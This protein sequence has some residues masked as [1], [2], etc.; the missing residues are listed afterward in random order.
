MV[1]RSGESLT[2]GAASLGKG[3]R[4]ES[5][6]VNLPQRSPPS[7]QTHLNV[8]RIHPPMVMCPM[9][10]P[11]GQHCVLAS[12]VFA[13][14]PAKGLLVRPKPCFPSGIRLS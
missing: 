12:E 14:R 11:C 4:L 8:G 13:I 6:G 3:E 7:P 2:G 1:P 10:G 5:A 9:F